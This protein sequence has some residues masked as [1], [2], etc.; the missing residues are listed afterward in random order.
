[1][2]MSHKY[3]LPQAPHGKVLEA[4]TFDTCP[5]S[6]LKLK[7]IGVVSGPV[8][9][10]GVSECSWWKISC[11]NLPDRMIR[12]WRGNHSLCNLVRRY[13]FLDDTGCVHH[14]RC[15]FHYCDSIS[16]EPLRVEHHVRDATGVPQFYQHSGV[17][18]FASFCWVAFGNEKVKKFL[19]RH[20]PDHLRID[21]DR[22]LFNRTSAEEY[23]KKL[24]YE[25]A[26]GDDVDDNP[27]NDGKNGAGEF[28]TMCAKFKVPMI[29]LQEERGY[30]QPLNERVTD[31]RGGRVTLQRPKPHTDHVLMLR[32]TDGD[33]SRRFPLHRRITYAKHRYRLFG[34]F[35]GQRKCGHQCGV[36]CCGDDWRNWGMTDA[37]AHK[38]GI[39]PCFSHFTDDMKAD[40]WNKW[41]KIVNITKYGAGNH[42]FC[43]LTPWNVPDNKYDPFR[44]AQSSKRPRT[45]GSNS[46]DA[47]YFYDSS[48]N[49]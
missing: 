49:V 47:L 14:K 44:G 15:H 11:T 41:E 30:M 31:Q 1:M 18:W 6:N 7:C 10:A 43:P 37:D 29:R 28:T 24:W 21:A 2:D 16:S 27:L 4:I 5:G 39:G 20:H 33:H 34:L 35:M 19:L 32:F 46:I 8:D 13:A 42:E 38:D 17:C 45:Y 48:S 26:V 9:A 12:L 40:W 23:R 25:F 22:S 3:Q 36:V